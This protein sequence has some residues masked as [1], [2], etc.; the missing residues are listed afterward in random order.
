VSSAIILDDV[1]VLMLILTTSQALT[2][3]TPHGVMTKR[4]TKVLIS[5][6]KAFERVLFEKFTQF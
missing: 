3:T 4:V 2:T 1:C 6:M 5:M